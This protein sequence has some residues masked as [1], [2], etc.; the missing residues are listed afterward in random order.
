MIVINKVVLLLI[1]LIVLA[2]SLYVLFVMSH[3]MGAQID[4]Q[5]QLRMCCS[6]FRATD[7]LNTAIICNEETQE[8]VG[9]LAAKLNMNDDLVKEFCSCS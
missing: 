2:I 5:N 6:L 1:F 8:T 3:P 7:C 4:L 9:S